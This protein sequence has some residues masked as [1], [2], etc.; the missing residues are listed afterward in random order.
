MWAQSLE[1]GAFLREFVTDV[2]RKYSAQVISIVLFGSATTGEWIKG[3][4]DIDF[5]VVVKNGSRRKEIENYLLGKILELDCKYNLSLEK[6]CSTFRKSRNPLLYLVYK[7][8]SF[9]TFGRPLYVLSYDQ[10]NF[11]RGKINDS[12]IRFV[13]SVFDSLSI[14]ATKINQ[15]GKVI[16]G[17]DLLRRFPAILSNTEKIKAALAPI[18]LLLIGFFMLPFDI[19]FSLEH[20]VKATIWACE[21]VLFA[22]D[23]PL[24]STK[25]EFKTLKEVFGSS[26]RIDFSHVERTLHLKYDRWSRREIN[27]CFVAKHMFHSLKFIFILYFYTLPVA[28]LPRC[29]RARN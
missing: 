9:M 16:Y 5:I 13:T 21:D 26:D 27:G 7:T 4:S 19:M 15:T 24:S 6:T 10:I 20:S 8:E 22:L 29:A 25:R 18:W 28:K 23:L 12:R 1:L 2:T 14:F 11:E 17:E 3:K